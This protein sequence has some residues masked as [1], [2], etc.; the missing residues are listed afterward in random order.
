MTV[1]IAAGAAQESAGDPSGCRAQVKG[2]SG[3]R[4]NAHARARPATS[5]GEGA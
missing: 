4:V 1:D 5:A 3:L 2:A